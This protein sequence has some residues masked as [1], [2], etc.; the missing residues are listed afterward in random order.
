MTR[1][2]DSLD[3]TVDG[4]E[5]YRAR[6]ENHPVGSFGEV[7]A[8]AWGVPKVSLPR[9]LF[10][11]LWTFDIPASMWFLY[12]NATQVYT[13]TQIVSTN[14]AAVLTT[15]AAKTDLIMES[16]LCPRY[17]PNRGHLFS[18]ALWC[19]SKTNDGNRDFGVR[20]TENG[21]YFRLKANGLLYA[22]LKSGGVETK[23]E[24]IDT[25][26]VTG[27]DVQKGNVYDI[28]Y[29]WRGVGNYKFFINLVNVHAFENLG[30][31]TALSMQNPALPVSYRCTRTTQDVA[32]HI[33][34]A[35]ITSE[36]GSD[37]AEQG[38]NAFCEAV[39]S[40][41]TDKPV[42]VIHNPLTIA[43]KTNTRTAILANIT[44]I[45]NK[46]ATFKVWRTRTAANITGAT[47]VAI[48]SGS[49]VQTDSPD[50][51]AGAVR[52]TAYTSTGSE[53]I[54]T[55]QV[56]ALARILKD[57]GREPHVAVSLV[58]GDYLVVTCTATAGTSDVVIEWGEEV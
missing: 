7:V 42:L 13:S 34:C 21:V 51:V 25:S 31:L 10:H 37:D 4:I 52:A 28:Q 14:G 49:Y 56:E 30:T 24:L 12:E 39:S 44:F 8:D 15:S 48:G 33:G 50:V 27:F 32:M 46:K 36:N 5:Y 3:T 23:E 20:T 11:G 57:I 26:A 53:R 16:R 47:L 6:V 54:A 2:I 58:R 22:V 17:Q 55:V 19:P 38:Q 18:S 9:S 43:G 1:R 41:G 45:C 29:Q 35:D 40:T